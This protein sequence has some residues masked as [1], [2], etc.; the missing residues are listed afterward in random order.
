VDPRTSVIIPSYNYAR[1]LRQAIESVLTQT[2]P[3][4][5]L[6]IVDDGS[7]DGSPAIA[8]SYADPRLRVIRREH[9]GLGAT[10]NAGLEAARGRYVAFLD[11]DD[12]WI[13][14]K[15]SVQASILDRDAGTGFVYS[16][17]GVID[18]HDRRR[19]RGHALASPKPSGDI[20]APLLRGNVIGTPSTI[21]FRRSLLQDPALRFDESGRF[22]EDWHFYLLAALRTRVRYVAL[23]LAYHRLHDANMQGCLDT[24]ARQSRATLELGLSLARTHLT[25]DDRALRRMED[26]LWAY[27]WR[28]RGSEHLKRGDLGAARRALRQSLARYRWDPRVAMLFALA[29]VGWMPGF[30]AAR[31][32]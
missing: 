5:E 9:R 27:V 29:S 7:S 18:A 22:L 23:T 1:Y 4:L 3:D 32:K 24:V 16:R 12:V 14:E 19:S 6:L 17:F 15:L 10:R 21:C 11:A 13:G 26:R 30:V 28:I 2:D 20:F 25:A 8:E 31:L